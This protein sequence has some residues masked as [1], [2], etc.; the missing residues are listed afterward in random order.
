MCARRSG[1]IGAVLR[2][3]AS[4]PRGGRDR[5]ARRSADYV[6][7][8]KYAEFKSR[9]LSHG[10]QRRLEIARALATDPEADRARAGL[11]A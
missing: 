4:W 3:P 9:T 6:G 8:G 2:N 5:E 7:I 1:L 10:D 11:P